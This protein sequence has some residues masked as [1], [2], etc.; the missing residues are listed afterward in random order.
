M[1]RD[2][3]KTRQNFFLFFIIYFLQYFEVNG[4]RRKEE[5]E[6]IKKLDAVVGNNVAVLLINLL[7]P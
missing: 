5:L 7:K 3:W 2:L 4:V 6:K 1:E